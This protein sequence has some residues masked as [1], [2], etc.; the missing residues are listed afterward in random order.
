MNQTKNPDDS[1]ERAAKR[2]ADLT[3][4]NPAPRGRVTGV[5]VRDAARAAMR[6]TI[7]FGRGARGLARAPIEG[8]VRAATEIGGETGAF[9]KDAVIGVIEGTGQVVRVTAPAVREV[10]AGSIRGSSSAEANIEDAG[11]DVVEGAIVGA[12]SV[13][14]DVSDAALAAASAAM[15]TIDETHGDF[16]Q[17]VKA[18]LGGVVSGVSAVDGDV[19]SAAR[20]TARLVVAHAADP[21]RPDIGM[22]DVAEG[23]VD[24]VLEEASR[25]PR[26]DEEAVVEAAAVGV[27][28]AAYRLGQEQGDAARRSV[29]SRIVNPGIHIAPDIRD[30]LPDIAERLSQELP[31]GRAAWRGRALFEAA[32]LL[33][34]SG[35]IDLAASLAFF[36][37]L[38]ILPM[39]ALLIM[40]IAVLGDSDEIQSNLTETLIYYFPTSS[41]LIRQAVQNILNASVAIGLVSAASLVIGAGGMFASANRTVN[42]VFGLENERIFQATLSQTAIAML[43]AILFMLS[44]GLTMLLYATLGFGE[45]IVESTGGVSS[46]A[47]I[48]LGLLSTALPIMVTAAMFNFVYH[49]LP[50]ASVEWRDSAFGAIVA[51]A[52]FE[53][54]KHL[55]FWFT[56]LAAQR[57]IIYGP[58]TSVVI[59]LMWTYVSGLIFLYGAALTKTAGDL[60]PNLPVEIVGRLGRQDSDAH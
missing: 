8:S 52:L 18:S 34:R 46:A 14:V 5:V 22:V 36:A 48:A 19:T 51:I 42:R 56:S 30:K 24:A 59:L 23:A 33:I 41:E 38:S 12:A 57:N 55:F 44:V 21:D 53:F 32:R 37:T 35:G 28:E 6:R 29:I 4:K 60:R 49:R 54:G 2:T 9:V 11:R 58:L 7:S 16:D 10:V 25:I 17:A 15:E 47:A 26:V 39:V 13:G 40:A 1:P 45:G 50:N 3:T 27:V 31:R 43:V 20:R